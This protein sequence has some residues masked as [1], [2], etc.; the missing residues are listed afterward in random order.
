VSPTP[1]RQSSSRLDEAAPEAEGT[2]FEELQ[3]VVPG[4][5]AA[6]LPQEPAWLS[7]APLDERDPEARPDAAAKAA[8]EKYQADIAD[9]RRQEILGRLN[10]EQSR[11]VTTTDG[12]VLILAGA[13]S[14]KTRVL[15]HRIAYLVGVKRVP[16]FRILAVT[17]TN[18]AAA[19]LRERIIRLVGEAGKEVQAG[20]FHSICAQVLRRDGGAIG[21]DRRFVIYDTDDQ[22][23]LMKQVLR[24]EGLEAKGETRP[25]AILGAISRAK[26]D[27][28][29]PKE[30]PPLRLATGVT[31]QIARLARLYEKALNDANAVDFDD[32]LLDAVRLFDESPETLSRYQDRW[33]YLHVDEYQDTN[34]PQ[35]LWIRAL[36]SKHHNLAVVGDDDQ[37]IYGWRG[38]DIRN[39]LDFERDWPK[40]TVIKLEQNYRS[41]QL[42]LDAAHAVVSK[43]LARSDKKLWTKNDR[44]RLI[45]RFEAYNEEEEA[46]WIVRRVEELTGT[47]GSAL[48]RRADDG[49]SVKLRDIAVLYRTNAQS[50][51]IE[52]ACLRY[53]LRYQVVGGTRFYSRREVKDALAYLRILRSDADSVSFERVI[54]VPARAIGDKTIGVIRAF[55]AREGVPYW[56]GLERAADGEIPELAGRARAAIAEFVGLVRRLR[57]RI[58]MLPLPELVD[59]VL[60][61]SGYRAMLADGTEEGEERWANLLEL[62]EVTTRYDDLSA[63]DALDRLLEETALVADQ[64]SYQS[65]ADMLSLITMHA[66]K[67]LEFDVVF[68]AG[69]E[70]SLFPTGRAVEAESGFNPDPRPMEEERRLAYVGMTRARQRLYLSHAWQRA[71]RRGPGTSWMAEPSRFLMEIPSELMSGPRLGGRPEEGADLDS[72][73]DLNLV[74]GRGATRFGRAIRPGGG[75]YREGSG[76][77]GA[78]GAGELFRPSRD[79][80]ARREAFAGGARS[81]TFGTRRQVG[82]WDDDHAD[83]RD[84]SD[85]ADGA[86][87]SRWGSAASAK[88]APPRTQRPVIPGERHYRDGDR[89]RHARWGDGIV[90]SSKLTRSDEEVTI[91]FRDPQIGRKTLLASLAGLELT[92]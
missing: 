86:G 73:D 6:A 43:N 2:R 91:A 92:G 26:N 33:R 70:E 11:A 74:F 44:G 59:D 25:A 58:G 1:R 62:R 39:I 80:N 77:P 66:A 13:G 82:P 83:A 28:L 49:A 27:M 79:L 71:T 24:S 3:P 48:T 52:E 23:Q 53:G 30:I 37:S 50:R 78:P 75:A 47:R 32:L 12:P 64:D 4:E 38:A 88:P 63:E 67:G 29:D 51:A 10:P 76:R 20:T 89:V 56:L 65:D 54:N 9:S 87:Q 31:V 46:E 7:E 18:R 36:A 42:I 15:A 60:E 40:A 5:A 85:A 61:R 14:G 22:Q 41:T 84:P 68:I 81:G 55:V 90:V 16:P 8:Q 57:S 21:L 72:P 34:R 17:F 19:E 69:M 45:E 35:Y